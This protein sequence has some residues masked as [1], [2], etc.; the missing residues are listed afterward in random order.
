MM[1][2]FVP[3][4]RTRA[5]FGSS[6]RHH[7][8]ARQHLPRSFRPTLEGL[9]A[10][11]LLNAGS[12]DPTF[13]T[14]GEVVTPFPDGSGVTGLVRQGD[15][16]L[17]AGGPFGTVLALVRYNSD[18]TR[19]AY[20][21]TAGEST[22]NLGINGPVALALQTD[23]KILVAGTS[24]TT[25]SDLTM[26]I[27]RYLPTGFLDSTFG[28]GSGEVTIGP[29]F[30]AN[31][32]TVQADGKILVGGITVSQG[33]TIEDLVIVRLNSDGAMD[34]AFGVNGRAETTI[35]GNAVPIPS[36]LGV[37][38]NGRIVAE[39]ANIL[40]RPEPDWRGNAERL[41]LFRI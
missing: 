34:T 30:T 38:A 18:G 27:A 7:Q 36:G 20:F 11:A 16:K 14:G 32:V 2:P 1:L 6:A 4:Q 5:R 24:G 10:R 19:D 8:K 22:I 25:D 13:G 3:S 29:G 28:S 31:Q 23:G 12:L 40:L 35:S 21:A 17:V 33:T 9:E 37:E 26:V 39:T 15:G 41:P